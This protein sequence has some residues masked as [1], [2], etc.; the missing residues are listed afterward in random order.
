M[1]SIPLFPLNTVLFPEGRLPLRIFEARY[2]DM[3]GACMRDGTGFGVVLIREGVEA[4]GPARTFEIGTCARIVDFDQPDQGLLGITVQGERR[5]RIGSQSVETD[6]LHTAE[7]E[8]LEEST[9]SLE[10]EWTAYTHLLRHL[11]PQLGPLYEQVPQ[12]YEDAGWVIGRLFEVLPLPLAIKQQ[13]LELDLDGR[14]ELLQSL[15]K[16]SPVQQ[17]GGT[18]DSSSGSRQ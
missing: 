6:G 9:T 3:V 8:W 4:G 1:P 2:I 12:R 17:G 10:A 14:F 15:V 13:A 18:E 16:I 11:L 7:I 5:F